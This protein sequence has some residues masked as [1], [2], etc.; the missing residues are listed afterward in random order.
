MSGEK[1]MYLVKKSFEV[2]IN[3]K[4]GCGWANCR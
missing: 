1:M 3:F 4:D 2:Y